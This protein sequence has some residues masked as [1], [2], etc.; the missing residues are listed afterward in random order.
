LTGHAVA[1]DDSRNDRAARRRRLLVLVEDA[2]RLEQMA[3]ES[4]SGL[5]I[6]LVGQITKN[7]S[8]PVCKNI[9]LNM[10]PK[11]AA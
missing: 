9:P 11:S 4:E 8:S 7:L 10:S 5:P 3:Q 1:Q 2:K 6:S